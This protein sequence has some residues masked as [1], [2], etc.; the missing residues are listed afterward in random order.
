MPNHKTWSD[1]NIKGS[2][3]K[4]K[5]KAIKSNKNVFHA[6]SQKNK[7]AVANSNGAISYEP[8]HV[9]HFEKIPGCIFRLHNKYH[10]QRKDFE[11][12]RIV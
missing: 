8:M 1:S 10:V 4:N 2:E 11:R 6:Y 3:T 12:P 9:L 7:I 5:P